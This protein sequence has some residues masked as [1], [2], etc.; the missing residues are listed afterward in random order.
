MTIPLFNDEHSEKLTET[1]RIIYEALLRAIS[2]GGISA[3]SNLL[4]RIVAKLIPT[5]PEADLRD[6]IDVVLDAAVSAGYLKKSWGVWVDDDNCEMLSDE[7]LAGY[8]EDGDL[9]DPRTGLL[10]P[11]PNGKDDY[12]I[13]CFFESVTA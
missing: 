3:T 6:N 4:T 1:Q 9:Y 10:L 11:K 7:D 12:F 13:S 2:G 8:K 5:V